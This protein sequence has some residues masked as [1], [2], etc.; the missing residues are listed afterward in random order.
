MKD[1]DII[2]QCNDV[3]GTSINRSIN[4]LFPRLR[5]QRRA[6]ILMVYPYTAVLCATHPCTHEKILINRGTL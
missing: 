1:P 6:R 3:S 5:R 2:M 4:R